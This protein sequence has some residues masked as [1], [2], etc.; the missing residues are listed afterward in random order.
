MYD[1]E[2]SLSHALKQLA[3][4]ATGW[5]PVVH[6]SRRTIYEQTRRCKSDSE[7]V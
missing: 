7:I 4:K 3:F 2:A 5:Q 1:R 6:F